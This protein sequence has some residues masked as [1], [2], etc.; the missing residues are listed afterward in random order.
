MFAPGPVRAALANA[1]LLRSVRPHRGVYPTR[2]TGILRGSPAGAMRDLAVA[3]NGRIQAVGRSF[4]LEGQRPEYFSLVLPESS[5][6]AGRNSVEILEVGAGGR[7][8][9]LGRF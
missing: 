9:S 6:H 4:R 8:T 2:V 1:R 7:L 3:A 5:L